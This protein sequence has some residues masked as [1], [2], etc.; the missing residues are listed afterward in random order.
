MWLPAMPTLT[1]AAAHAASLDRLGYRVGRRLAVDD[2]A[3]LEPVARRLAHGEHLH[4]APP[5]VHA[6][7]E[8]HDLGRAHVYPVDQ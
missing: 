8:R 5:R 2:D 6:A 4:P 3:A 7:G 1:R